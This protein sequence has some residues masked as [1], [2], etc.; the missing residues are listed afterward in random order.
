MSTPYSFPDLFSRLAIG[1]IFLSIAVPGAAFLQKP[2]RFASLAEQLK[3]V[4]R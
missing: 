4:P 3:L 2:F 1:L